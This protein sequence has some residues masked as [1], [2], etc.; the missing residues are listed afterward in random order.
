MITSIDRIVERLPPEARSELVDFAEF[1]ERKYATPDQWP[2]KGDWQSMSESSLKKI[3][4]N[5][6]DDVYARLL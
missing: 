5:S 4:D 6:E 3:W 1:L 2:E